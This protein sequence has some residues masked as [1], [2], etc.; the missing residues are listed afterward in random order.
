MV[1]TLRCESKG[2][3]VRARCAKVAPP[4]CTIDI[5]SAHDNATFGSALGRPHRADADLRAHRRGR[6][7][8]GRGRADGHHPAH[9]EPAPS[10]ARTLAGRAPAAALHAR[11]EAHRGRRALLRPRQGADPELER[12]RSRA[13]RRRRPPRG[14]AARGGAAR[15][16]AAV[17]GRAAGRVPAPLSAD[18]RRMAAARRPAGPHA[19]LHRRGRRLRHPRRR[20]DR[21]GRGRDP[22]VGGAAHRGRCAV[23]LQ[24][25]GAARAR[26][27]PRSTA[28]DGGAQFLPHRDRAHPRNHRRGVP[29]ADPPAHDHRQPQCAAQRGRAGRGRR[30]A[31]DLDAGRGARGRTAAAPGAAMACG[32]RAGVHAVPVRALLP[33]QAAALRGRHAHGNNSRPMAHAMGIGDNRTPPPTPRSSLP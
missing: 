7:P 27:R 9:R 15:V 4:A 1:L 8:L 23:S 25:S 19:R 26:P 29:R 18:D 5:R 3:S 13:A 14:P 10:G 21:P 28:L 22:A 33:G 20:G 17:A 6:Q 24:G 30:R 32:R 16:R 12:F 31:V 11:H 2:W